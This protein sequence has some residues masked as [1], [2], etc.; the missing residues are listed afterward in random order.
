MNAGH[1]PPAV[2]ISR[3]RGVTLIELLVGLAI[4]GI[5]S[6]IAWPSYSAVVQR[7]QRNEARMALL[8]LQHLQERHYATHLR[9]AGRL[10]TAADAQT[11][12]AQAR[13]DSGHYL[14]AVSATED[15]QGFI[16]M[17]TARA[18]GP[19]ARDVRCQRLAVDHAGS[20][21]SAEIL[22]AWTD[23]DPHRCWG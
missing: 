18:D 14:L 10:G 12:V 23:T 16:A 21:R 2:Q 8:Q 11:L 22:G 20:R 19:Q 5:L 13:T 17:A 9:Y 3:I 4:V 7:A 6:A 15:G 1:H